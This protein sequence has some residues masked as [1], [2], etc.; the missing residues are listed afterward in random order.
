MEFDGKTELEINSYRINA[1]MDNIQLFQVV[2][3]FNFTLPKMGT[4]DNQ[5]NFVVPSSWPPT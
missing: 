5:I 2:P 4:I 3:G 1:Y